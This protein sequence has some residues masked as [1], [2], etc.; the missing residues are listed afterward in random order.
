[1]KKE[2]RKFIASKLL[3]LTL[4]ILPSCNFKNSFAFFIQN[5]IMN[6]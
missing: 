6:L 4:F 5:E 1:M 2:F 3:R